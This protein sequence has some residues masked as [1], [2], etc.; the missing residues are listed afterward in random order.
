MRVDQG[1]SCRSWA[2]LDLFCDAVVVAD[3]VTG[4]VQSANAPAFKLF[5]LTPS[6]QPWPSLEDLLPG[7]FTT[8]SWIEATAQAKAGG[9]L[10]AHGRVSEALAARRSTGESFSAELV[11]SG[12]KGSADAPARVAVIV[13]EATSAGA[14][15]VDPPNS[16]ITTWT[17]GTVIERTLRKIVPVLA[18]ACLVDLIDDRGDLARVDVRH[19]DSTMERE[20]RRLML[21]HPPAQRQLAPVW[22]VLQSGRLRTVAELPPGVLVGSIEEGD[23]DVVLSRLGR[24]R[25]VL[26]PLSTAGRPLG[27]LTL[28]MTDPARALGRRTLERITEVAA[29]VANTIANVRQLRLARQVGVVS[30]YYFS[31]VAHELRSP[32]ARLKSH[33]EMATDLLTAE[34]PEREVALQFIKQVER[35]VDRLISLSASLLD[36]S[37]PAPGL[38]RSNPR[39][40]DLNQLVGFV[41]EQYAADLG[42]MRNLVLDVPSQ[43]SLAVVDL[44]RIEQVLTN[45]LDNA[46]KYSS[47]GT[48]IWLSLVHAHDGMRVTVR[49]EGI[50]LPPGAAQLI[51]EPFGRAANVVRAGLPG[52]GLGLHICRIIAEQHGG[53]IWAESEG[54]GRGTSVHLVLPYSGG[55]RAAGRSQPGAA[56]D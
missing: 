45:L 15:R 14:P 37:W 6:S 44:D 5:G 49:D 56:A 38:F 11:M 16:D 20:L 54:Q 34:Q 25:A 33:A 30:D 46:V 7:V 13:R 40:S 41:G 55:S 8:D 36:A 18:D 42:S 24:N 48:T 2:P 26:V 4:L 50:G 22:R 17:W 10:T 47:A 52:F 31:V 21:H 3:A 19:H 28:I 12:I 9:S 35:S 27:A 51:F 1:S 53:R 29:H 43:P 39:E 32:L 23:R